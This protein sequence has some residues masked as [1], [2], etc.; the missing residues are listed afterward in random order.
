MPLSDFCAAIGHFEDSFRLTVTD[1]AVGDKR[2]DK[3]GSPD[4]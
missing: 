2:Q 4:S 3:P 1:A